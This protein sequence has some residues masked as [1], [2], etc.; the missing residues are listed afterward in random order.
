MGYFL[1]TSPEIEVPGESHVRPET[2]TPLPRLSNLGHVYT[3][4]KVDES[5]CRWRTGVRHSKQEPPA[6]G[7]AGASLTGVRTRQE[8][9]RRSPRKLFSVVHLSPAKRVVNSVVQAVAQDLRHNL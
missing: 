8:K 3:V 9:M 6:P 2:H 7:T 5:G 1:T 4:R